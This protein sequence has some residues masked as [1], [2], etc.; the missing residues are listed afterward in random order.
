[1]FWVNNVVINSAYASFLRVERG[2]IGGLM[3]FY[4]FK[5]IRQAL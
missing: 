4:L 5:A 2:Q 1:M 3:L